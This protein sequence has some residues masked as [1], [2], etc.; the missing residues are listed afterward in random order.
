MMF[1]SVAVGITYD[2]TIHLFSAIRERR[3]RG[4]DHEEAM[5]ETLAEVGPPIVYTSV[6]IAAGLGI[7]MLSSIPVMF[8]LG[9]TTAVVVL[10]A[11]FSDLLLTTALLGKWG[12]LLAPKTPP[13]T[14][15]EPLPETGSGGGESNG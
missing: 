7:F 15:G 2:N 5:R 14:S 12:H 4:L 10:V 11:A 8:A 6:L 13:Q 3:A 9:L 1:L